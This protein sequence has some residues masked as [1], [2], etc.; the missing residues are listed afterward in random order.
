[1]NDDLKKRIYDFV[2]SRGDDG[3]MVDELMEQPDIG[4]AGRQVAARRRSLIALDVVPIGGK[5]RS[6]C[7]LP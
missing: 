3:A 1:M 7:L 5:D 4:S 6:Q 2:K